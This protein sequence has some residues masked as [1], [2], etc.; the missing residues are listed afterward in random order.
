M[1]KELTE[2]QIEKYFHSTFLKEI[3]IEG[4]K[5]LLN[6]KVLI[7]GAGG[8]GSNSVLSLAAL[9][10][11]N[12]TIIDDDR[13]SLS[14]LARQV[15]FDECDVGRYKVDVIKDK[16]EKKNSDVSITIIKER[17]DESNA[18]RIINGHDI[19]LDCTDNFETKFLINDICVKLSVPFAIVGVSDFSGQISTC[20]P[21]KTKDF[22]SLFSTL[23]ID[24]DKKYKE[25]DQGVFP[26][27]VSVI[28]NIASME[29]C[30]YIL[31][32]GELLL[33]KMLVVNTLTNSF[34]L[35]KF[36]E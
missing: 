31:N 27:A 28:A 8:L 13:V 21:H 1:M 17:L 6:A 11:G 22:K 33:N 24:I 9:G 26:L 15:L 35:F 36:P 34:K 30:K 23:P 20:L 29:V 3:G 12:I 19:V 32:I 18:S 2:R 5:K 10:I 25:E 7:V 14:N 4:Q 16:L